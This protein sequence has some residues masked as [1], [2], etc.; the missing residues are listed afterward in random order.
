MRKYNIQNRR[1]FHVGEISTYH[2]NNMT[3]D[4]DSFSFFLRVFIYI[5]VSYSIKKGVGEIDG[6]SNRDSD[7]KRSTT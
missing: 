2:K 5:R 3:L 6:D 7:G 1:C 4:F